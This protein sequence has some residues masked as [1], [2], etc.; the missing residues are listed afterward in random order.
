MLHRSAF[1]LVELSIVLVILGLLVGGVLAGQSLIRAAELR[2]TSTDLDKYRTSIYAFREKYMALPG[3]MTN[4]TAFWGAAD[5]DF[6]TCADIATATDT[7]TCNGNGNGF[8]ADGGI[9][10]RDQW[11][12]GYRAWQHLGNAGLVE[13]KYAGTSFADR[14]VN[15]NIPGSNVPPSRI[16]KAASWGFRSM[17]DGQTGGSPD[18]FAMP[19]SNL[20]TLGNEDLVGEGSGPVLTPEEAW[21]IDTKLDDGKPG[22]GTIMTFKGGGANNPDCTVDGSA[23]TDYAL[24]FTGPA[25]AFNILLR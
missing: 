25:C 16:G 5:A 14:T 18:W 22:R 24:S 1:T 9:V 7:V 23:N 13:G 3:D 6:D 20:L 15:E 12:E 21:N 10:S 19:A 17:I 4:A 11:Y 8:I 2:T